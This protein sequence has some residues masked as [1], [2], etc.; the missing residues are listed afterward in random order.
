MTD[1]AEGSQRALPAALMRSAAMNANGVAAEDLVSSITYAQLARQASRCAKEMNECGIGQG[2][3][4]ALNADATVEFLVALFAV[5]VAGAAFLVLDEN[6]GSRRRE[7]IMRQCRPCLSTSGPALL[8]DLSARGAA[9]DRGSCEKGLYASAAYVIHTSGSTGE[10]KGVIV[11]DAGLANLIA[12]QRRLFGLTTAD[13]VLQWAPWSFDAAVFDVAMAA[14]AGAAL[15]LRSQAEKLPGDTLRDVLVRDGINQITATPSALAVTAAPVSADLHTVVF[16]GEALPGRVAE[17]WAAPGRRV[18]NAYGPAEATIWVTTKRVCSP[19]DAG[20]AGLPINGVTVEIRNERAEPVAAGEKGEVWIGGPGVAL[21]YLGAGHDSAGHRFYRS[22]D[23]G[24]LNEAGELVLLGR[25]DRQ[26]K[27]H[28][29]RVELREIEELLERIRGVRA[30]AAVLIGQAEEAHIVAYLVDDGAGGAGQSD[31]A[32]GGAGP[33]DS[34]RLSQRELHDQLRRDLPGYAIPREFRRV[35]SLPLTS[36]GKLDYQALLSV[37]DG[38]WTPLRAEPPPSS[39]LVGEL[40]AIWQEILGTSSVGCDEDLFNLG[41][42]SLKATRIAARLKARLDV[43][44]SIHDLFKARTIL[45]VAALI[46][47]RR[48]DGARSGR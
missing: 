10:P 37:P 30:C 5:S 1:Q 41:G 48:S 43:H 12:E 39:P 27:I 35:D 33:S 31:T 2:C 26:V 29:A 28:A 46:E 34:A 8:A 42:N 20:S 40:T 36:N 24:Y 9:R 44:F 11:P 6:L 45:N 47:E 15:V 17:R 19:E 4:V 13:R 23:Y 16:A 25:V 38:Q 21:G 3:L 14:G 18:F 32:A 7:R 22:G